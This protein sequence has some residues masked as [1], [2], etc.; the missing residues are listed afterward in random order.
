VAGSSYCCKYCGKDLSHLKRGSRITHLKNCGGKSEAELAVARKAV[1]RQRDRQRR[2]RKR[3]PEARTKE[4][5]P[6]QQRCVD[7]G[8]V[9]FDSFGGSRPG[10]T[11]AREAKRLEKDLAKLDSIIARARV[12]YDVGGAMRG[13]CT[14]SALTLA[15]CRWVLYFVLLSQSHGDT[16]AAGHATSNNAR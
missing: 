9:R 16:T 12:R 10:E 1:M 5:V 13:A 8:D 3:K 6:R 7:Y 14:K 11:L 15:S 4:A 2:K